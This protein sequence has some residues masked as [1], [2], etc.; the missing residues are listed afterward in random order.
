MMDDKCVRAARPTIGSDSGSRRPPLERGPE[1]KTSL[2]GGGGGGIGEALRPRP[3]RQETWR[4]QIWMQMGDASCL[5]LIDSGNSHLLARRL[6][7]KGC[8]LGHGSGPA[9]SPCEFGEH[10]PLGRLPPACAVRWMACAR[11]APQAWTQ[12]VC[13]PGPVLSDDGVRR[14]GDIR[15]RT[16]ALAAPSDRECDQPTHCSAPRCRFDAVEFSSRHE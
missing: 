15:G 6:W 5:G 12:P 2:A 4:R 16:T 10:V 7:L 9:P 13:L 8:R 1:R 11:Q 3:S 14:L